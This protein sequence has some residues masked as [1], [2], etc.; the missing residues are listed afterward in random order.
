MLHRDFDIRIAPYAQPDELFSDIIRQFDT[1]AADRMLAIP[2]L[3]KLLLPAIRAEFGMAY[4]YS[5]RPVAPFRFPIVSFVGASDPW[6]SIADSAGWG[7]LTRGR[8]ANHVRDGS[9]F[10]MVDDRDYILE[11]INKELVNATVQ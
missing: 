2:K 3:R 9:H 1:P 6:V 7:D 8:F 10:L 4:N 5:H 11:T